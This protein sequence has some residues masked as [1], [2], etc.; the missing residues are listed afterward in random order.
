M[1]TPDEPRA[2]VLTPPKRGRLFYSGAAALLLVQMFLGFQQYYLHGKAFRGRDHHPRCF[3]VWLAGGGI[4]SGITHGATDD[5]GYNIIRD[6]VHVHD[7]HATLLHCLGIDHTR[8]TFLYQGRH[9]RL[10]DVHG[11]VI[12]NILT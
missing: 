3:T 9:H 2:K 8:L 12:E 4:R 10:T 1:L 7:L 5:F 6:P 11:A